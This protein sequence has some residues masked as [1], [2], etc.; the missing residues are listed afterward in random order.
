MGTQ[1]RPSD[2][3]SLVR[4]ALVVVAIVFGLPLLTMLFAV[5]ML[6]MWAVGGGHMWGGATGAPE[7]LVVLLLLVPLLLV[8]LAVAYVARS[9]S[10]DAGG[11]ADPALDELRRAYARGDLTDEEF[12]RRRERLREE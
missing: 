5:P 9:L 4:A 1:S 2:R 8:L 6:G 7:F 12:E 3:S 10:R 11:A